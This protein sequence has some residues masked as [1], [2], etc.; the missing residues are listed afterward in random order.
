M[1]NQEKRTK[2]AEAIAEEAGKLYDKFVGF[3][4]DLI[5]VGKKIDSAK[6]TYEDS[7]NKLYL[8]TGNLINRAQKMKKLGAKTSK[9]IN[10]KLAER[11]GENDSNEIEEL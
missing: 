6:R 3:L 11:A 9:E 5:D 1:W 8:G 10:T 4:D 7:M 2:N